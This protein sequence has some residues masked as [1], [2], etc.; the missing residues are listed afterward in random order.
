MTVGIVDMPPAESGPL[1]EAVFDHAEKREFVYEHVWPGRPAA[2]GQPLLVARAHRF[3]LERAPADAAHHR[4]GHGAAVL[5][6]EESRPR[7]RNAKPAGPKMRNRSPSLAA[8]LLAAAFAASSPAAAQDYPKKQIELVVPFVAGGTTDNVARLM[9][10]RFAESW[11]Q[12]VIVNNAR[13]AAARSGTPSS[14]RR[15]PTVTPCWSP[16]SASRSPP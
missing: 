9:A 8:L 15:R 1:L 16:P 4:Q 11:G 6:H 7:R 12:T 14:P 10:Q 5:T 3:P 2:L 13:A